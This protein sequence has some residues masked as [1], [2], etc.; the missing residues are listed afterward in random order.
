MTGQDGTGM[1]ALRNAV[2]NASNEAIGDDEIAA[3]LRGDGARAHQ[4]RALFE[5]CS[6]AAL[7]R[8]GAAQGIGLH[9]ILAAY[10]AAKESAFAVNRE[11]DE[12][13]RGG[14]D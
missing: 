7:A 10:A 8:A 11:L 6:L 1:L 3:I 5:D 14:W 13:L 4:V 9:T 2:E 12:A